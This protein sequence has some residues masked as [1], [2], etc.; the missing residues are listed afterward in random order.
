MPRWLK[1]RNGS[2]ADVRSIPSTG[3]DRQPDQH[4]HLHHCGELQVGRE[5]LLA[6]LV[7]EQVAGGEGGWGAAEEG[8]RKEFAF[9]DS[10]LPANGAL[11]VLPEA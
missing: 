11:L 3:R 7:A 1:V 2:K 9:G 8:E 6:G 4:T 5:G 10:P